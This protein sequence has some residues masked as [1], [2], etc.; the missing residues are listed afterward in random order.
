MQAL[1]DG[2]RR[3]AIEFEEDFVPFARVAVE[4]AE[5]LKMEGAQA[6][7]AATERGERQEASRVFWAAN[8]LLEDMLPWATIRRP[9]ASAHW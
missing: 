9:G 2:T 8:E 5:T 7:G 4:L 6:M 1:A 3:S